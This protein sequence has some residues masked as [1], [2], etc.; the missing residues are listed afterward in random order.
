MAFVLICSWLF[1]DSLRGFKKLFCVIAGLFAV[2]SW[3]IRNTG[4]FFEHFLP[5]ENAGGYAET[6]LYLLILLCSFFLIR[7]LLC[8]IHWLIG[9]AF[10]KNH[11][12]IVPSAKRE[13]YIRIGVIIFLVWLIICVVRFPAGIEFDADHQI[14]AFLYGSSTSASNPPAS[15]AAMGAIVW[16]GKQLFNNGNMGYFLLGVCQSAAAAAVFTYSIAVLD[17]FG[18]SRL[19]TA[20]LVFLYAATPTFY[21]WGT[22]ICKDI[23]YT[24]AVLLFVVSMANKKEFGTKDNRVKKQPD[25]RC[26]MPY[27]S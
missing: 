2:L 6:M 1:S 4:S 5:G 23:F 16:I 20:F 11:R 12:N 7:L 21:L 27:R 13:R 15:T 26:V 22:S 18:T 9:S 19:L 14:K 3:S 25:E 17:R 8:G 24:E 10:I